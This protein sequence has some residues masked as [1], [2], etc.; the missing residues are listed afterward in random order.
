MPWRSVVLMKVSG[1]DVIY[2]GFVATRVIAAST[3]MMPR[4]GHRSYERPAVIPRCH[5]ASCAY[6]VA[7][8]PRRRE[9]VVAVD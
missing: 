7:Q 5:H 6:D 4:A 8:P 9:H 3:D 1:E 2:A